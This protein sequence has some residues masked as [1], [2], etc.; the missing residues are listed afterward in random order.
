M[1]SQLNSNK[2]DVSHTHDEY[3]NKRY[4]QQNCY[5]R[6]RFRVTK[7][8]SDNTWDIVD[9]NGLASLNSNISYPFVV[10]GAGWAWLSFL[11]DWSRPFAIVEIGHIYD[12]ESRTGAGGNAWTD[13][14]TYSIF[15]KGIYHY[16]ESSGIINKSTTKFTKRNIGGSGAP[17]YLQIQDHYGLAYLP[18]NISDTTITLYIT[19][20]HFK[21]TNAY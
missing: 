14:P 13:T 6:A 12:Y 1:D 4:I 15:T 18:S 9:I 3:V 16:N 7:Y 20:F 5:I 21:N 2:A 11:I 17:E 19:G 8:G 10:N